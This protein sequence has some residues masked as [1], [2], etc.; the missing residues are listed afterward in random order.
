MLGFSVFSN[1]IL[2]TDFSSVYTSLTPNTTFKAVSSQVDF[3]ISTD[4]VA[5][6][7]QSSSTA[8]SRD[9]LNYYTSLRADPT[10][11]T[12]SIVIA[13]KYFDCC[14]LIHCRCKLFTE[15]LPR[16]ERLHWLRY[17]NVQA[18]CHNILNYTEL[19]TAINCVNRRVQSLMMRKEAMVT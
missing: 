9:Y 19:G 11:N 1:R 14:L 10:E 6:S 8:V 12:V 16:N 15:L 2:A 17:F 13:K 5:I 3:Q 4:L 7:S 18:S